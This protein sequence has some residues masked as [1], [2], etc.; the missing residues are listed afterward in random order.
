MVLCTGDHGGYFVTASDVCVECCAAGCPLHPLV[1]EWDCRTAARLTNVDLPR[2]KP[3][4][5]N[6]LLVIWDEMH[7]EPRDWPARDSLAGEDC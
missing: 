3:L 4:L 7:R 2:F 1:H 6:D 5:E